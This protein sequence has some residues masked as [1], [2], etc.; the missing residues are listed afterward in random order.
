MKA[1]TGFGKRQNNA[2]RSAAGVLTAATRA[3][4]HRAK[5][6]SILVPS[7][8][9]APSVKAFEYALHFAKEFDARLTVLHVLEVLPAPEFATYPIIPDSDR[10]NA[11]KKTLMELARK[12]GAEP[13]VLEAVK[14]RIGVPFK[15]ITR[16]AQ[17]LKMDLIIIATHGYT[18]LAH[19]LL[20]STAER[21]VRHAR[22][23]VLVVPGQN[24]AQKKDG[25]NHGHKT[26]GPI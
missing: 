5:I 21:V 4:A 13:D 6:A 14:I 26:K 16:A 20:G 19:V 7:D 18:G 15:E 25:T 24:E 8:F 22:C 10:I 3:S 11:L 9:S 2:P 17:S 23:P 12:Q 1:L